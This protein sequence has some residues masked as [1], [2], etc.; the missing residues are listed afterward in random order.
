VRAETRHQLKQDRFSKAT[1][2]AAGRTVDWSVEH[3]SK[4]IMAVVIAAVIA[5]AVVGGWYYINQQDQKASLEMSQAVRTLST[6]LRSPG[7]PAQEGFPTFPSAQERATQAHKQFQSI[8]EHYPHTRSA[9]FAHYFL[10][11][12]SADLGDNASAVREL[13]SVAITHNSDLAALAKFALA[14]V[15]RNQHNGKGAMDLYNNLI[16]KPTATVSKA[17]AQVELAATYE[18][19]G[20]PAEAR[21]IYQ[22]LQK[23]NPSNTAAGQLAAEKL[24]ALK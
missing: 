11:L 24:Q 2:E 10:G 5:V 6:P 15:Y 9:E 13:Q 14:A 19:D 4:V 18:S 8:V 1:F 12:T 7:T 22:Q 16:T 3:K 21:R 17:A 23:E 20:Q